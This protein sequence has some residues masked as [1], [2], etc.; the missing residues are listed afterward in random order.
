LRSFVTSVLSRLAMKSDLKIILSG[1]PKTQVQAMTKLLSSGKEQVRLVKELGGNARLLYETKFEYL[2][3]HNP[4]ITPLME[5]ALVVFLI[6]DREALNALEQ[7][8][9]SKSIE[10]AIDYLV[11]TTVDLAIRIR[12]GMRDTPVMDKL[13]TYTDPMSSQIAFSAIKLIEANMALPVPIE[14]APKAPAFVQDPIAIEPEVP[15]PTVEPQEPQVPEAPKTITANAADTINSL[16]SIEGALSACI[17]DGASGM[18][19]AKS[20]GSSINLDIAAAGV[21]EVLRAKQ[22]TMKAL[23]LV[24]QVE[25]I[26]ITLGSQIQILRPTKSRSA[27][28]LYLILDKSRSNLAL[29]RMKTA[30]ADVAL[31]L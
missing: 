3:I 22:K 24:E 26:L 14:E 10:S 21:T 4:Q 7:L 6:K 8:V 16:M 2:D 13:V 25:D 19:L 1:S 23:G 15:T 9:R 28:F 12:S 29:A 20:S 18:I 30:D 31:V 27:M 17:V 11:I 5:E